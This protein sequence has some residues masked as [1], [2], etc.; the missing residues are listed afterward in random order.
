[1]ITSL[2]RVL[3]TND[4]GVDAPG[5]LAIAAALSNAFDVSVVAPSRPRSASGHSV[6]LHKPLRLD[7]VDR[8]DRPGRWF[9]CSGT[10]SDCVALGYDVVLAGR[11]DL[12][13][14]GINRGANLGWDLTYSGTVMGAMEGIVLGAPSIAVSLV[15]VDGVAESYAVAAAF[16]CSAALRLIRRPLPVRALLNI[17]VPQ[18]VTSAH[19]RAM[20]T[21]QGRREYVERVVRREDP[22]GKPYYWLCGSPVDGADDP[23]SDV[24]AV[25]SGIISVTP[26]GLDL[27]AFRCIEALQAWG[28]WATEPAAQTSSTGEIS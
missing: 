5:L 7:C 11:A 16:A 22:W 6:T 21:H 20:V 14:S 24:D 12:V 17:N 27:T 28:D 19:G 18:T 13:V 1:M 8:D 4:D 2:P 9:A 23:G 3:L 10:P 26:I 25:R 15:C